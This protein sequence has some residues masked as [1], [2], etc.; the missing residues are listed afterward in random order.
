MTVLAMV[1]IR[2]LGPLS[3]DMYTFVID[4]VWLCV[5]DAGLYH[6][7]IPV[8]DHCV[9][10]LLLSAASLINIP[11]PRV[12]LSSSP[13]VRLCGNSVF[14]SHSHPTIQPTSHPDNQPSIYLVIHQAVHTI[15][16]LSLSLS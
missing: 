13:G 11:L 2:H 12:W 4:V 8:P 15:M 9:Y 3:H 1:R 16:Y 6:S 14:A 5:R 7:A 10:P